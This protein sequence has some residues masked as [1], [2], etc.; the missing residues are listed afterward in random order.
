M[1]KQNSTLTAEE[2]SG[3]LH[4]EQ[5]SGLFTW[6]VNGHRKKTVGTVAG[7]KKKDGY[8]QIKIHGRRY[9]AHRLAW[10]SATGAWPTAE[11]DHINGVRD[12]NRIANLREA[13]RSQNRQNLH[14]TKSVSGVVGVTWNRFEGKWTAQL[15]SCGTI[16]RL[17]YFDNLDEAVKARLEAKAKYHSR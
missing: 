5:P 3:I 8:V 11:I 17:G 16:Y 1:S 15:T 4:Y 10:L 12:D 6:L 7:T 14:R 9:Y 2:V 13:T